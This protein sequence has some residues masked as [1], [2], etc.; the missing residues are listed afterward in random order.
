M[1]FD[2]ETKQ[3]RTKQPTTQQTNQPSNQPTNQNKQTNKQ[4]NKQINKQTNKTNK[5]NKQN[6]Q[7]K[8][9]KQTLGFF[10]V[11]PTSKSQKCK[12]HPT[13][14]WEVGGVFFDV[15]NYRPLSLDIQIPP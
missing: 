6:K 11:N 4:T 12:P 2:K 1:D 8:Q 10:E 7:T 9:T 15:R 5:Q 14:R 3:N 13:V